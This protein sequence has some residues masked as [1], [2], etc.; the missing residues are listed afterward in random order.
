MNGQTVL[1]DVKTLRA[2]ARKNIEDGA[3]TESYQ[4]D[5]EKV[6]GMLNEGLA[7]EIVCVLRYK[8]HYFLASGM[9][10]PQVA[11]EFAEHATQELDHA[12]R[13]ARRIVELGGRPDFSPDGLAARSHSEYVEAKDLKG[14]I[15]EN[16][17]AERIAIESYTEMIRYVGE[18][19]PTTCQL[20][21]E[22]LA[23]EEE[24][25]N[26]LSDFLKTM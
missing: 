2:R 23:V 8:L 13:L 9:N 10:S 5:R 12:D 14:M 6:I 21:R 19:D 4:A 7:T 11:A 15:R 3:V 16:L 22:I 24:H 25:A 20:L 18:D 1:T 17:V 26:D